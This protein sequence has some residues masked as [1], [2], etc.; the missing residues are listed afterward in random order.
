MAF[1]VNSSFLNSLIFI[2]SYFERV[3]KKLIQRSFPVTQ[4]NHINFIRTN[5]KK[6]ILH[7]EI[8]IS[9]LNQFLSHRGVIGCETDLKPTTLLNKSDFLEV[10]GLEMV[11]NNETCSIPKAPESFSGSNSTSDE[12]KSVW[13]PSLSDMNKKVDL[14]GEKPTLRPKPACVRS[15]S[16]LSVDKGKASESTLYKIHEGFPKTVAS[17]STCITTTV[18]N[19]AEC[20]GWIKKRSGNCVHRENVSLGST[21]NSIR[22]YSLKYLNDWEDLWEENENPFETIKKRYKEKEKDDVLPVY[23]VSGRIRQFERKHKRISSTVEGFL[24]I[25]DKDQNRRRSKLKGKKTNF[26]SSLSSIRNT[27]EE[28]DENDD[29]SSLASQMENNCDDSNG[30]DYTSDSEKETI[31]QA[32]NS[33]I[34]PIKAKSLGNLTK[35]NNNFRIM[36]DFSNGNVSR[37]KSDR[38]P[39]IVD[40]IYKKKPV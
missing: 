33:S 12:V 1:E 4:E 40:V 25:F 21:R 19:N 16:C 6:V 37:S 14:V 35:K 3:V 5:I 13:D 18:N 26:S 22:S 23:T 34:L 38:L 27:K 2:R 30:R 29:V 15:K 9:N 20:E 10:L 8:A 17:T 28:E 39:R 24:D 31:T 7:L 32:K 11:N 36:Y